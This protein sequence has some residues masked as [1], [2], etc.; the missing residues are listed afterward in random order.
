MAVQDMHLHADEVVM[1]GDDISS[2]VGAAQSAGFR[3]V[4]VRTGKYRA[5]DS[6]HPTVKPDAI[7]GNLKEA[8]ECILEHQPTQKSELPS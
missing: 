5:S 3:G 1:I 8:V 2:D 6:S 7:V 4:L